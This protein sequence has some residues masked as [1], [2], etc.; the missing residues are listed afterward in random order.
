[1]SDQIPT[2]PDRTEPSPPQAYEPPSVKDISTEDDPAFTATG[3]V[4]SV[5]PR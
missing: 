4:S 3:G 5:T 2:Q 1:M